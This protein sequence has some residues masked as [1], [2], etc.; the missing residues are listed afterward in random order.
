MQGRRNNL[1][2]FSLLLAVDIDVHH[3]EDSEVSQ[4]GE[5]RGVSSS[6]AAPKERSVVKRGPQDAVCDDS[7]GKDKFN[8]CSYEM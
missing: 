1:C 3:A 5:K 8:R 6:K 4:E 7:I 2:T